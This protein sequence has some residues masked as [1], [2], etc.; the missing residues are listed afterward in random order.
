MLL[1]GVAPDPLPAPMTTE[2]LLI[3]TPDTVLDQV[4]NV[5]A[6]DAASLAPLANI[7][8]SPD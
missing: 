3:L 5:N 6:L 2:L 7:K 8:R 1:V 4:V